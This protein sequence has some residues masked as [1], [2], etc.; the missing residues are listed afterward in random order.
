VLGR[1]ELGDPGLEL[2][3]ALAQGLAELGRLAAQLLV[4]D[5]LQSLVLAVDF[6]DDR[7]DTAALPVVPG[8]EDAVDE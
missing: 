5:A 3:G 6:V 7:L 8:A 1:L 4:R 2:G